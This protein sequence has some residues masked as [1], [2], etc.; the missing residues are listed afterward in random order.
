MFS[1]TIW[2][3]WTIFFYVTHSIGRL[4]ESLYNKCNCFG[5]NRNWN[6]S[7]S[8]H[9]L[10]IHDLPLWSCCAHH[11][12][13]FHSPLLSLRNRFFSTKIEQLVQMSV[14]RCHSWRDSVHVFDSS[15]ERFYL[16]GWHWW[17][18]ISCIVAASEFYTDFNNSEWRRNCERSS[19]SWVDNFDLD[20]IGKILDQMV[21]IFWHFLSSCRFIQEGR[22]YQF[23]VKLNENL[24][25]IRFRKLKIINFSICVY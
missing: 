10:S 24:N 18:N 15:T 25:E 5:P 6:K 11:F 16:Y 12:K 17:D 19:R 23:Q 2:I 9:L 4:L 22:I 20:E 7:S 13:L 1:S 21:L 3:Q 8:L 14:A